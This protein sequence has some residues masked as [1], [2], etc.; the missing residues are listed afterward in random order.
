LSLQEANSVQTFCLLRGSQNV[1]H[2][3]EESRLVM[4]EKF[5]FVFLK[6][7]IREVFRLKGRGEKKS[8]LLI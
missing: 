2:F 1:R 8:M 5:A 7:Y 6:L 3:H 4:L